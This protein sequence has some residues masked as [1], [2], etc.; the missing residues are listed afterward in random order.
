MAAAT[1]I[2]LVGTNYYTAVAKAKLSMF[3]GLLRKVILLIPLIAVLP[4]FF[5]LNGVW[6]AQPVA[7]FF[8]T[9]ITGI[10]IIFELKKLSRKDLDDRNLEEVI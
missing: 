7:D 1:C 8:T 4:K 3:L 5:G 6:M 2:A 9:L 10:M